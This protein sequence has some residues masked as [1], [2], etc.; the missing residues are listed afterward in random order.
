MNKLFVIVEG[1]YSNWEIIG[2][3]NTEEEAIDVCANHNNNL[4][5]DD[6]D[7]WYYLEIEQVFSTEWINK[8]YLLYDVVFNPDKSF[9]SV[10]ESSYPTL[11]REPKI[12]QEDE[13]CF[14]VQVTARTEEQ[15]IKIAKDYLMQVIAEREGIC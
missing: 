9:Y 6:Y 14:V 4:D 10:D 5:L 8:G 13:Y 7:G 15:A 3:V 2:Y 11:H 12:I 1:Q